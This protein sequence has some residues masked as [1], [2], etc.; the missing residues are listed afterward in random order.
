MSAI[1][2]LLDRLASVKQ[3]GERRWMAKSPLREDR[4]PSV[5]IRKT[6]DGRILVHD[7]GGDSTADILAALGLTLSDLFEKRL[8]HHLPPI[9]GGFSA[10]EILEISTHESLVAAELAGHA[11]TRQ[12]TPDETAR[13]VQAASRLMKAQGLVHGR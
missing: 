6:D 13:L 10:R 3:T 11:Q 9:R 4:T 1:D 8:S 5:S 7:F 2:K 12:L